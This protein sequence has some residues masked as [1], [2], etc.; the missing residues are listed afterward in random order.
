M[1]LALAAICDS[2]IPREGVLHLISAGLSQIYRASYPSPLAK[3]IAVEVVLG[4]DDSSE[5]HRIE[6]ALIDENDYEIAALE[7]TLVRRDDAQIPEGEMVVV[8]VIGFPLAEAEIPVEG[9]YFVRIDLDGIEV[10][11]LPLNAVLVAAEA[12]QAEALGHARQPS[13]R[14]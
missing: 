5:D 13:G 8:P 3:A 11:R 10:V 7:T 9:R 6:M 14:K 4:H 12:A 1:K 2:A